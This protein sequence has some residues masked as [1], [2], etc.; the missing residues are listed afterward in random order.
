MATSPLEKLLHFW[1]TLFIVLLSFNLFL[2]AWFFQLAWYAAFKDCFSWFLSEAG[3]LSYFSI[4][5]RGHHDQGLKNKAF[6]WGLD[7][8]SRGWVHDRHGGRHSPRQADMALEQ[9]AK[10]LHLFTNWKQGPVRLG[11][12][13]AFE[14]TKPTP[15]DTPLQESHTS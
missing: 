13:W 4:S 9:L 3:C 8:C 2:K 15:S 7:Y 6:N 1:F 12:V 11:L 14:T 10:I 5:A